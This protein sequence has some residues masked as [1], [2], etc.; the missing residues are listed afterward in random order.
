[1][2]CSWWYFCYQ[3]FINIMQSVFTE[4]ISTYE[5]MKIFFW[6]HVPIILLEDNSLNEHFPLVTA[7]IKAESVKLI[8]YSF[9]VD[10][11]GNHDS[12]VCWLFIPSCRHGPL[13]LKHKLQCPTYLN[14]RLPAMSPKR[15]ELLNSQSIHSQMSTLCSMKGFIP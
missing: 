4:V 13:Q 11:E 8:Y 14:V 3:G 10:C 12:W 6:I 1:M 2:P 9:T 15:N 7:V 5:Y